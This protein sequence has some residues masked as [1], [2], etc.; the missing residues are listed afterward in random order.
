MRSIILSQEEVSTIIEEVD[1]SNLKKIP[2]TNEYE[3]LRVKEKDIFFVLHNT[4]KMVF[5]ESK[6]FD[7]FLNEIFIKEEYDIIGTDET[8][9]GEWYGPMVVAGVV[10]IPEETIRLRKMGIGD[11]KG[12]SSFRIYEIGNV[13]SKSEIEKEVRV[14]SPDR[15]NRLYEEFR[16]EKKN[17][18]EILSWAHAGIIYDL[19]TRLHPEKAKVIIDKFDVGEKAISERLRKLQEFG[20][21]IIEKTGGES[22]IAVAAASVLAKFI[23]E[24][25][26]RKLNH[27]FGTDLRNAAPEDIPRDVLSVVA[28]LEPVLPP[29]RMEARIKELE[30]MWKT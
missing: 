23:F 5:Q 24:E 30:T 9:K 17:L 22:E 15:Y 2:V 20:I 26:I 27:E 13:V 28:K 19:L 1:K 16:R 12:L 29:L 18:N 8:G 3:L 11:S 10:L 14:L 6:G 7:E 21:D 4:G 25:E